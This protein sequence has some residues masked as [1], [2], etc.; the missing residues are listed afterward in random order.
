MQ[1]KEIVNKIDFSKIKWNE[2]GLVPA[3]VQD[4]KDNEVLMVAF[5]NAE[6]LKLTLEK[7]RNIFLFT[8]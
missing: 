2:V 5:M 8:L 6:S 3:I 1:S 7:K 4:I